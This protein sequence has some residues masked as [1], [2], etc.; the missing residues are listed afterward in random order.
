MTINVVK[1]LKRIGLAA[2]AGLMAIS[3]SAFADTS[4]MAPAPSESSSQQVAQDQQD[5]RPQQ[6][7][8]QQGHRYDWAAYQPRQ[9]PPQWQQY[10]QGFDPHP[11]QVDR[12]SQRSYHSQPYVRP[13]GWYQQRWAYG[14]T[15]PGAFWARDYWPSSYWSFG[16][17]DPPYGYVWVRYGPDA[18]LVDVESGPVLSVMY[19][20]FV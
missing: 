13:F 10:G 20:V 16:L 1:T 17:S 14:Q 9:R 6:Q 12:N 4:A 7:Q 8:N 11:Y 3:T 18:L 5:Y 2:S 19:G 15:L